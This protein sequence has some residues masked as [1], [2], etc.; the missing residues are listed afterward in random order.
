MLKDDS[1]PRRQE[2]LAQFADRE[3]T[4]FLLRFW[5]RYRNKDTQA[6]LDTFLD[7]MHPTAIRLAAVHRYLLPRPASRVSTGSCALTSRARNRKNS[8][9]SA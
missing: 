2:Y 5:K 6:R 1:D 8:A 3:G 7:S 9:T 4:T